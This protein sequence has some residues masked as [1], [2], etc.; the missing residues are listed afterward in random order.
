MPTAK[1]SPSGRHP[2][3]VTGVTGPPA[4]CFPPTPWRSR[5]R[6]SRALPAPGTAADRRR[7]RPYTSRPPAAD[8]LAVRHG[9][10]EGQDDPVVRPHRMFPL[11]ATPPAWLPPPAPPPSTAPVNCVLWAFVPPIRSRPRACPSTA[12]AGCCRGRTPQY[13]LLLHGREDWSIP[14]RP[15]LTFPSSPQVARAV[16]SRF[17]RNPMQRRVSLAGGHGLLHPSL[18]GDELEGALRVGASQDL[19]PGVPRAAS[20]VVAGSSVSLRVGVVRL[21]VRKGGEGAQR[22][23]GGALLLKLPVRHEGAVPA[24]EELAPR[25]PRRRDVRE[26]LTGPPLA[27]LAL[28]CAARGGPVRPQDCI[29]ARGSRSR[30]P[31]RT[32]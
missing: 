31:H 10:V 6:R 21:G 25:V 17:H 9:P 24:R 4:T 30:P 16:P 12:P 8:D 15:G 14:V 26:G 29:L 13:G 23:G 20:D 5:T 27:G 3:L 1:D 19:A 11:L 7:P 22:E 2:T 28:P 32:G 18:P